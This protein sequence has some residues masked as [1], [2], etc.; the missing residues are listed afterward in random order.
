MAAAAVGALVIAAN[1]A[2]LAASAVARRRR[3]PR[4]LDLAGIAHA[5]IGDDRVWAGGAPSVA[6]VHALSERGVST[7]VDLRAERAEPVSPVAGGPGPALLHL[8]VRDGQPPSA[9]Q[10]AELVAAVAAA[11]GIV[12]VHCGAGV[13]RTGTAL[14]SYLVATGQR[15]PA[16]ALVEL[17]A[18][19]PPTI[20]QIVHVARLRRDDRDGRHGRSSRC[21]TVVSRV[22]VVVSRVVDAPRRLLARGRGRL[23]A[24]SHPTAP[25]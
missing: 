19:G 6:A 20:E 21:G 11:P 8:P 2:I 1:A 10:E 5:R 13:G 22:T 18:T 14:A 23:R 3:P 17:L 25:A 16:E 15:S 7:I 9:A 24:V 4:R 12:F